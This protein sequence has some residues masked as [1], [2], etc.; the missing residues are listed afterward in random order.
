[1]INIRFPVFKIALLIVLTEVKSK[2]TAREHRVSEPFQ[3][4]SYDEGARYK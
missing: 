4:E 3:L 1:M 2:K